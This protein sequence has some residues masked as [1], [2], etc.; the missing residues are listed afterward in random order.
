MNQGIPTAPIAQYTK[1]PNTKTNSDIIK[2][3]NIIPTPYD[4]NIKT[5]ENKYRNSLDKDVPKMGTTLFLGNVTS[6]SKH[7]MDYLFIK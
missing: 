3:N 6:L 7:A 4:E 5:Q 1:K 2:P